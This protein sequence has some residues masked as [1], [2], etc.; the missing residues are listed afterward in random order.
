MKKVI[1][2]LI[3]MVVASVCGFAADMNLANFGTGYWSDP[4]YGVVWEFKGD[5]IRIIDETT[6]KILYDF[7]AHNVQ[8]VNVAVGADGVTLT[9]DNLDLAWKYVIKK[10]ISLN[11]DLEATITFDNGNGTV[12]NFPLK[13]S[14]FSLN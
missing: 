12:H 8:N 7:R 11:A 4:R 2:I 13:F 14:N 9:Y 10:P 3:V 5:G 6:K 1:V